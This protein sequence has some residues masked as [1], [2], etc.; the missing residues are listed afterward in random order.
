[1]VAEV[2]SVTTTSIL[3]GFQ[4]QLPD[5]IT[6]NANMMGHRMM[7]A[8]APRN[9]DRV[10]AFSSRRVASVPINTPPHTPQVKRGNGD[11]P[12]GH[13]AQRMR[14]SDGQARASTRR[15]DIT[16]STAAAPAT[17]LPHVDQKVDALRREV[18]AAFQKI[19][20]EVNGHTT[21]LHRLGGEHDRVDG[22]LLSLNEDQVELRNLVDVTESTV[23]QHSRVV[24]DAGL[25]DFVLKHKLDHVTGEIEKAFGEIRGVVDKMQV[26]KLEFD[27]KVVES[28]ANLKVDL[29]KLTSRVAN[30]EVAADWSKHHIGKAA[31]RAS[32][33]EASAA[34][35]PAAADSANGLGD[36]RD[37]AEFEQLE[38][39]YTKVQQ[40][41]NNMIQE[42]ERLQEAVVMRTP[43]GPPGMDGGKGTAAS[44]DSSGCHC[45]HVTELVV[46]M[47]EIRER[48]AALAQQGAAGGRHGAPQ[49]AP[50]PEPHDGWAQYLASRA[51]AAAGHA[52]PHGEQGQA[53]TP[54]AP[55]HSQG[56]GGGWRGGQPQMWPTSSS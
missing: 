48:V 27:Q 22:D 8:T 53:P 28:G 4:S 11:S 46:Q 24:E 34:S 32:R 9:G 12:F 7:P 33:Q 35:G 36:L 18:A 16:M 37:Y 23:A 2:G 17:D 3:T 30:T 44:R 14:D 6:M 38:H 47:A 19:Q 41:L 43:Q 20:E 56:A 49:A 39:A 45:P 31:E 51:A 21:E 54:Q 13:Y 42:V 1:M 5:H 50:Q 55:D 25:N 26:E 15:I 52:P 40:D 29:D 10:R